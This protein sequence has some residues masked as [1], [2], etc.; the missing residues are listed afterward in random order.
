M[1]SRP[2]NRLRKIFGLY[3]LAMSLWSVSAFLTVSGL[4]NVLTWFK[5][6]TASPVLMTVAIFFFIQTLFGYRRKWA[7]LTIVYGILAILITY[8]TSITVQSASLDQ[9]GQLQL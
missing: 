9:A 1:V 7:P 3:L 8:F 4:G 2:L 5:V 6:M